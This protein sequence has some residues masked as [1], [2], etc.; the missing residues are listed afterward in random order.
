M[1]ERRPII[2]TKVIPGGQ[3]PPT[4]ATPPPPATPWPPLGT[5][6]SVPPQAPPPVHVHVTLPASTPP[7]PPEQDHTPPWWARIRWGRQLLLLALAFPL[8]TP[9]ARVLADAR[10]GA[11]LSG[12]WVIAVI[13][14]ALVAFW[15]NVCRIRAR[16]TDPDLWAPQ[17]RAF[18]AR[19]L[20]YA[21]VIA[22]ARALPIVTLV[23]AITGVHS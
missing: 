5:G 12:A 20:L 10:D 8:S 22:T 19:L 4:P 2:P 21:A 18:V 15:D 7:E 13:P 3:Q 23:Y 16:Y 1:I 6:P 11:G 17:I 9:W 14:L